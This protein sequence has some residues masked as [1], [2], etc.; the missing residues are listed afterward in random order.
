MKKLSIYIF[1]IIASMTVNA[2][3]EI[4]DKRVYDNFYNNCMKEKTPVFTYDEFSTYCSCTAK[5]VM[6]NFT[7]QEMVMLEGKMMAVDKSEQMKIVAANEKLIKAVAFC[8]SKI[9]K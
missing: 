4:K 3:S 5:Q 8:I 6:K 7:M 2:I 9:I 1:L